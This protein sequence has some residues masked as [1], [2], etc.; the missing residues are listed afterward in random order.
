MWFVF[1]TPKPQQPESRVSLVN[2]YYQLKS[3]EETIAYLQNAILVDYMN[4]ILLYIIN[5]N[6]NADNLKIFFKLSD[7]IDKFKI[8]LTN[9]YNIYI[10]YSIN[11]LTI[12]K[13]SENLSEN[14]I[15]I[16]TRLNL[17]LKLDFD[18]VIEL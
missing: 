12:N 8:C 6:W 18:D 16:D 15:A 1:P 9:L 2:W 10:N 4:K 13:L 5:K 17:N 14:I 11:S 7:D 3:D